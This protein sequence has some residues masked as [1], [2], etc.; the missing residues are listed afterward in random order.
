ME[1][2][3]SQKPN[4]IFQ[5]FLK[6]SMLL[7]LHQAIPA[8]TVGANYL[9]SW[10]FLSV[11]F[12]GLCLSWTHAAISSVLS[13]EK[14]NSKVCKHISKLT[15]NR[16]IEPNNIKSKILSS[17]ATDHLH[18]LYYAVQVLCLHRKKKSN[19]NLLC[20]WL[21]SNWMKI[22]MSNA[23]EVSAMFICRITE[24]QLTDTRKKDERQ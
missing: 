10:V 24:R 7:S 11:V 23:N 8:H 14:L 13:T 3:N 5:C 15:E 2:K 17:L 16:N 4:D 20:K 18:L 22:S 19:V 9:D 6:H 21:I 12:P 1:G